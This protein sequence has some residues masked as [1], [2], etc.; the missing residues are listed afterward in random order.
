MIGAGRRRTRLGQLI[1]SASNIA[2]R[3]VTFENRAIAWDGS[4]CS[5]WDATVFIC[6]S[7]VTL[8]DV[9]ID[10]LRKGKA[11]GD[12]NRLGGIS[13]AGND[14]T[15]RNVEVHRIRDSKGFQGG[16]DDLLVEDSE[17]RNGRRADSS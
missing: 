1:S 17:F 16:G 4:V 11:A 2:F 8:E 7:G 6:G 15:L 10:G 14:V 12:S 3:D 5:F 13:V 9:E